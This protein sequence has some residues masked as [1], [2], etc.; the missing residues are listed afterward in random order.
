MVGCLERAADLKDFLGGPPGRYVA[1]RTWVEFCTDDEIAGHLVWGRPS[2]ADAREFM[3]VLPA[4]GAPLARRRQRYFDVRRLETPHAA[5]FAV[6]ALRMGE[7]ASRLRELVC[8]VAVVHGGGL[9]GAMVRGF[10]TVVR[11]PFPIS[12]FL[13]PVVALA[14]LG[15]REPA[16]LAAELSALHAEVIGT[17]PLLRDL[18]ALLR[19]SLP[20]PGA[21]RA[22]ARTPTPPV[23]AEMLGL[24]VRSLQRRLQDQGTSF[25]LEVWRA[26][27]EAAK[28]MLLE[29][30]ATVEQVAYQ[31]GTAS[32]HHFISVFRESTGDTPASWRANARR[33]GVGGARSSGT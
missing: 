9:G 25:Q 32:T 3:R 15:A 13:D 27:V 22:R 31:L 16:R 19:N 2:E 28:A 11:A 17:T 33:N 21:G 26:R 7:H 14:S 6:F 30:D 12:F 20:G 1:G 10:T 8:G 29:T 5:A 4:D 23:V 24:S 18:R